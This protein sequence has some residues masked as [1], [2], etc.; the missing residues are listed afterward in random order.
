MKINQE[1][2]NQLSQLDRIEF[3]QKEDRIKEEYKSSLL[4][5]MFY[6]ILFVLGFDMIM[7]F[8]GYLISEKVFI[9]IGISITRQCY[10]FIGAIII[11]FIFDMIQ[12]IRRKKVEESLEIEFF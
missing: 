4:S 3:R 1:K 5:S 10:V 12:L 6:F 2:F 11:S 7:L 8:L 9:A